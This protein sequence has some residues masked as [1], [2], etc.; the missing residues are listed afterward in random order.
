MTDLSLINRLLR[1][2]SFFKL[3]KSSLVDEVLTDLDVVIH[4]SEAF[5][6]GLLDEQGVAFVVKRKLAV[7]QLRGESVH[8]R[9][10]SLLA[11]VLLPFNLL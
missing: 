9:A 3:L 5:S 7:H 4:L 8:E 11:T 6:L 1:L 2:L 10:L